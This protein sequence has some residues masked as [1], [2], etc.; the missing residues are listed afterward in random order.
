M[1]LFHFTKISVSILRRRYRCLLGKCHFL[2]G[3]GGGGA[4]GNFSSFVNF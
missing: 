3:G 1:D 4:F 2:P